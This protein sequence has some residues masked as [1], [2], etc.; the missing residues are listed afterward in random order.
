M[1]NL[2]LNMTTQ[3]PNVSCPCGKLIP[4]LQQYFPLT[5]EA[6]GGDSTSLG[7]AKKEEGN[8]RELNDTKP[9]LPCGVCEFH[10]KHFISSIFLHL[11]HIPLTTSLP[12]QMLPIYFGQCT[13]ANMFKKEN[14]IVDTRNS[15]YWCD[16]KELPPEIVVGTKLANLEGKGI[17]GMKMKREAKEELPRL[18]LNFYVFKLFPMAWPT[19]IL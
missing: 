5:R 11:F 13:T 7:Q 2:P 3:L 6:N 12:K 19:D 18:T 1:G 8:V 17:G 10:L 4:C 16:Y 9:Y 15:L 14:I